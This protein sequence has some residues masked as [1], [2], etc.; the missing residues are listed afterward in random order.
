MTDHV[1]IEPTNI[2]GKLVV[3]AA[4]AGHVFRPGDDPHPTVYY[5]NVDSMGWIE[6]GGDPAG[7]GLV[8]RTCAVP[9]ETDMQEYGKVIIL[10]LR[11]SS[12]FEALIG[13]T[14]RRVEA[15]VLPQSPLPIG[16]SVAWEGG[17]VLI[18]NWGDDVYVSEDWPEYLREAGAQTSGE[19]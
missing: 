19:N 18:F 7:W 4:V 6:I 8:W 14:V 1:E 12:P 9:E 13:S 3:D 17:S 2:V 10:S 5:L 16:V 15:V 11:D